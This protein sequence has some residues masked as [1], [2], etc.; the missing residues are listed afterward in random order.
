MSALNL[1]VPVIR[2]SLIA[3]ASLSLLGAAT[4]AFAMPDPPDAPPVP[5]TSGS[6]S[7]EQA[8]Q[9]L[10]QSE[11]TPKKEGGHARKEHVGRTN[12]QL[13]DRRNPRGQTMEKASTFLKEDDQ[14][15]A[16][17]DMM[18]S[19]GGTQ[20]RNRVRKG[21]KGGSEAVDTTHTGRTRPIGRVVTRNRQGKITSEGN[22]RVN[23]TR[24]VLKKGSDGSVRV[25]TSFPV[26]GEMLEKPKSGPNLKP[27]KRHNVTDISTGKGGLRKVPAP[28]ESVQLD[29]QTDFSN[30]TKGTKKSEPEVTSETT[31]TAPPK[32]RNARRRA[33]QRERAKKPT[34]DQ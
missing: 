18:N 4:A 11:A 7:R 29:G 34:T 6:P 8:G 3:L 25:Q 22:M 12:K 10:D 15:K 23:K 13:R 5:T 21:A 1:E 14:N 20:T 32:S 33:N 30:V 19:S 27:T 9:Y 31:Q 24:T 17:Q 16:T 28:S 2:K 26:E